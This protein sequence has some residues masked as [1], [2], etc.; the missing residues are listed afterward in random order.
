MNKMRK[1]FERVFDIPDFLSFDGEDYMYYGEDPVLTEEWEN[2]MAK[3]RG[4]LF[5]CRFKDREIKEL[6][7]ILQELVDE[8]HSLI[9]D[10]LDVLCLE[11]AE[12]VLK[13]G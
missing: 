13:D 1:E 3:W 5:A 11:R 9:S 4:F 10:E 6:K 8:C 12:E 2:T 7:D